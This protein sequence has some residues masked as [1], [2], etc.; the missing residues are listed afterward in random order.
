MKVART[1]GLLS[2]RWLTARQE[3]LVAEADAVIREALEI[4]GHDSLLISAKLYRALSGR[5]RDREDDHPVQNDWNGSA[6]VALISLERSEIAWRTIAA[7]TTDPMPMTFVDQLRDLR[8]EVEV[9]FPHARSF[10]RPA[11]DAPDR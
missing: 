6:K 1:F 3:Q 5:D 2:H 9:A 8:R 7:A 10:V 11:F 4:A